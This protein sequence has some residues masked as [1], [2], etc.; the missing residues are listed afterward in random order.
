MLRATTHPTT[1]L[2]NA[3]V[4]VDIGAVL[5]PQEQLRHG[6]VAEGEGEVERGEAFGVNGAH[7]GAVLQE[8]LRH[9][10]EVGACRVVQRDR[11]VSVRYGI[12][13]GAWRERKKIAEVRDEGKATG[14]KECG[15]ETGQLRVSISPGRLSAS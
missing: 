1:V 2:H 8:Q 15:K 14:M 12:H 7:V 4:D 5:G 9:I 3:R 6:H 11:A 10:D 13:V